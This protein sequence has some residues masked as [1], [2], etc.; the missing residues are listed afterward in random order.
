[1]APEVVGSNPI[2][3]TRNHKRKLKEEIIMIYKGVTRVGCYDTEYIPTLY[4]VTFT[5]VEEH[6]QTKFGI[7]W[8]YNTEKFLTMPAYFDVMSMHMLKNVFEIALRKQGLISRKYKGELRIE[9]NREESEIIK[10]IYVFDKLS[11]ILLFKIQNV[12]NENLDL[13]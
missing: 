9:V 10:D 4:K 8:S 2:A 13:V 3:H 5:P 6:K 12:T 11:D 1:M 7:V